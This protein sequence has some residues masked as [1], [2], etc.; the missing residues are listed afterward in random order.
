[1]SALVHRLR[2]ALAQRWPDSLFG[3]L[4][5][6]LIVV[7][8]ASHALALSLMFEMHP[9]DLGP[10][11]GPPPPHLPGGMGA[12]PGP[13]LAGILLDVGVRLGAVLLAAWVGARW[14]SAPL[15]RLA[16]STQEL[17]TDIHRTPL[18]PEGTR[19]C[20]EASTVI[21]QLQ[22]HILAQLEE[23][24]RF[25]AA[26]SHDLR[27]PLTRLALRAESLDSEVERQRFGN[28]I[29]EMDLMIRATLDHLC[30]AADVEATVTLDLGSLVE[31]LVGDR[32]DCGERVTLCI[33]M[34]PQAP[35]PRAKAQVSALRRAIGNL[36]D[37]AVSYG[38][39]A[40]V[41]VSEDAH[42]VRV[43]VSDRGP[44]IPDAALEQVLKPFVRLEGSRNRNTG[45]VGLGLSVVNDIARRHGGHVVLSNRP[46]GGL[47]A[48]LVMPR[49][50]AP[51]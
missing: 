45:G 34:H 38:G 14:L 21:N 23:R 36:I 44:G 49:L 11:N 46:G 27:T 5:V 18:V 20:R 51:P 39:A 16:R 25:V 6:L 48:E 9:L 1:M 26:V 28:D 22:Q 15:H 31:S 17:A 4:A 35:A 7:A 41:G 42:S 50:A 40:E 24:D 10:P 32:Q 37:N 13:P 30:G 8:V 2:G 12:P 29:R 47:Q 43:I 33:P 3:R 19:E